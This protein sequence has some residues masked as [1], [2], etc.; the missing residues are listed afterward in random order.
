MKKKSLVI[1]ESPAKAKT[2]NKI[3]GSGFSVMASMGHV[4]DLPKNV[5]GVEEEND[6]SPSYQILPTRKKIITALKKAAGAVSDVYLASDP[7]REGEAICWHITEILQTKKNPLTF[8]R[9]VFNEITKKAVLRSFDDPGT[10]DT[11]KVE[12]QQARRILDRLVGYKISPLLWKKVR[13]GLSA[14]RVQSVALKMVVQ[15]EQEIQAFVPEEYWTIKTLLR[16]SSLPEIM[17]TLLRKKGEKYKIQNGDEAQQ[18]VT[19]LETNPFILK[20]I[21][22]KE[23]KRRPVPPFTTSKLQQDASRR[24]KYPVKKTMQVAQGLY[25]GVELGDEGAVGLITYMRTDSTRV[26]NEALDSVRDFISRAYGSELLPEKPNRYVSKKRTQDAHEAI[27]PTSLDRTPESVKPYLSRDQF[28]LY[29]LIWNRFVA[30]Q[31]KEARYD[32]T[33]FDI[34]SGDYELRTTGSVLKFKGFLAVYEESSEPINGDEDKAGLLPELTEGETLELKKIDS[35]QRFTQPLPRYSEATLVKELEENGIGRPSTYA[36]ILSILQNREYTVKEEG[37]FRPTELGILVAELLE[38]NFKDIMDIGY[39]ARLEEQLDEIEEGKVKWV[40]ALKDF[41]EKFLKDLDRAKKEMR[42][43]KAETIP[44]DETCEKCGKPMLIRWGRF[45]RFMAC[46]DYPKCKN[47]RDIKNE[48]AS[49]EA[50]V[51]DVEK[52]EKCGA[53]MVPKRGRFG[54]FLACSKYPEC[55]NTKKI[56]INGQGKAEVTQETPLDEKCPDCGSNLIR[57][58]GKFGPFISCTG[59]PKCRYIKPKELDI[60]C[61]K[62]GCGGKVTERKSK[63]GRTFYGCNRYPDCDFVS[64]KVPINK[65]CPECGAFYLVKKITK[66]GLFV[67]CSEKDCKFQ[68]ELKEE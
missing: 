51:N 18:V 26:A 47:T 36:T 35:D 8:Y 16:G 49:E 32:A 65:E 64:W 38:E 42:D 52:C 48:E 28:K 41:N 19:A 37:R 46:S 3:L 31:M 10:I 29:T 62:E 21:T 67:A 43:I 39:T 6:F 22:K 4:R 58:T 50:Q 1:V 68:E 34:H 44:T 23:K 9:V 27:R 63:R 11:S 12:A 45:G 25:E 24:L 5:L 33:Q 2:I 14:G 7:D 59:Y 66:K 57:R 56:F 20:K 60:H 17:A 53:D 61:P 54:Q 30:S 40:S 15:R 13:R 55:K